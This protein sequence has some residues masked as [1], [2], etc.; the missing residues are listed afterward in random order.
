M[1]YAPI[2]A[3][4]LRIFF[5]LKRENVSLFRRQID[6]LVKK[7]ATPQPKAFCVMQFAKTNSVIWCNESSVDVSELIRQLGVSNYR[8]W[9]LLT[10]LAS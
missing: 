6:D 3:E 9:P 4:T 2:A 1:W 10:Q 7:M 8:S 5:K